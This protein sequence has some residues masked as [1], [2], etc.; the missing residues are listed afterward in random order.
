M[1]DDLVAALGKEQSDDDNKKEYCEKQFDSTEDKKKSLTDKLNKLESSIE[2][3]KDGIATATEELAALDAAVKALNKEV[4]EA[5]ADR[6]E[7]N[8][9]YTD[10]MAGDNAAKELLGMAK[11]RLNKFYNPKLYK[12]PAALAEIRVHASGQAP[13]APPPE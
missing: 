13:P 10:L 4:A 12:P 9:D 1:I 5:T 6:K 3:A 8:S 11:N 2:A 7:E